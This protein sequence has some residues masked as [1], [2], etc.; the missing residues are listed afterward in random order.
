MKKL[1]WSFVT[2]IVLLVGA[3]LGGCS[4]LAAMPP[5]LVSS[6]AAT[7]R[8][9][10]GS[11][12]VSGQA[13]EGIVVAGTGMS[14]ADPELAEVGFGVELRGDNADE[15][16]SEAA[17]KMDAALAAAE[18]FGIVEDKTRTLNYNLW[19]ETV[20][21]PETGRPTGE[22]VYH[23]SHQMQVTTDRIDA[24][25]GLLSGIVNA[26]VNAISGVNFTVQ[27]PESLMEQARE[28]AITDA[29]AKAEQIAEQLGVS[30][31]QPVLVTEG[32]SPI[33]VVYEAADMGRG[34]LAEAAAP[35]I[36]PGSFSVSV[37]IQ[38][39]YDIR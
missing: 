35:S 18:E 5:S 2:L 39:V 19:V 15:L 12:I 34:G 3:L 14:S 27:D 32:G 17:T 25:G 11:S 23:L 7:L 4:S 28:A 36:T 1:R 30:L 10:G 22:I 8:A 13:A 6:D 31:G 20:H 26:G 37:N 24:V 29:R 9:G 21:D 33:P 16:V 38:I